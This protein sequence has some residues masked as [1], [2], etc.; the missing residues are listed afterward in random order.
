MTTDVVGH[1]VNVPL[2]KNV[3]TAN[4][5]APQIVGKD[6]AVQMA[7]VVLV[8]PVTKAMLALPVNACVFPHV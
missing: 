5:S 7:A 1:A 6:N 8:A 3:Q 4:A 2:E